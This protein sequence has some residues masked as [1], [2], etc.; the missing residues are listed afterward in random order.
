MDFE[1]LLGSKS[2]LVIDEEYLDDIEKCK[3]SNEMV[4]SIL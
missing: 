2:D 3:N 1:N 4:E